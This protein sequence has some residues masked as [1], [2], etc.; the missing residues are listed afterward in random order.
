MS[1]VLV[2]SIGGFAGSVWPHPQRQLDASLRA[3]GYT[4]EALELPSNTA[5]EVAACLAFLHTQCQGLEQGILL[6]HSLASRVFLLLVDQQRRAGRLAKPLVDTAVLLAPANGRYLADWVPEVA[7]FFTQDVWTP[8]LT[9]A[10][11]RLLIATSDEDPYWE[12]AAAD[13][14]VFRQQPGVDVRVLAGQGH[15]NQAEVSGD[16][17]EV[18]AWVL[19]GHSS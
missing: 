14:A 4:V 10:A 7:P 17:P 6:L 18:R 19:A 5:P 13:L 15:L 9:G 16:L 3:A 8:T 12:E 11:R 1:T 2:R